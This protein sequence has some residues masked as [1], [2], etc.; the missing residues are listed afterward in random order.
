MALF[1]KYEINKL[2]IRGLMDLE[3]IDG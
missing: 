3:K 1:E 2:L